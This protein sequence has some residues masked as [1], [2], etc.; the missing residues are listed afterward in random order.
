MSPTLSDPIRRRLAANIILPQPPR[1]PLLRRLWHRILA[2][3][4]QI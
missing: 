1:P 3:L 4:E 2:I